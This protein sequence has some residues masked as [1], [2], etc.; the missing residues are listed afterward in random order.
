MLGLYGSTMPEIWEKRAK[1]R[2]IPGKIMDLCVVALI[3]KYDLPP[4]VN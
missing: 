3:P 2:T 4:F 1:N